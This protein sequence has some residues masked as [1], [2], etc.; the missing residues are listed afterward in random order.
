VIALATEQPSLVSD[1]CGL[2]R[3]IEVG[4]RG[5]GAVASPKL[6]RFA[7]RKARG[8][9]SRGAM[10]TVRLAQDTTFSFPLAD[11][12]WS[13]AF[14]QKA[15]YEIEIGDL[16]KSLR[17]EQYAFIDCG[18]NYG[19]W[20]V[21]VTSVAYGSHD[22]LAVELSPANTEILKINARGN[23]DRFKVVNAAVAARAGQ[24]VK[25]FGSNHF[26]HTITPDDD[27]KGGQLQP[28]EARTTTL[29][30]CAKSLQSRDGKYIVKLDVEGAE[31]EAM[32][33]AKTL[34]KQ[35][36]LVLYEDEKS[37]SSHRVSSFMIKELGLAVFAIAPATPPR[38]VSALR[39]IATM[40]A[41]GVNNF[42]ASRM[43]SFWT[44]HL[45][46]MTA[47]GKFGE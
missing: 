40:K 33:G 12:Y 45:N 30:D 19:Y 13:R 29:D 28:F 38:P 10:T 3:Y 23:G 46:A 11:S 35:E 24:L 27:T 41:A 31:C 39:D 26:G 4:L 18:A 6:F 34:M 43:D 7:S 44:Q 9:V 15:G 16:L 36:T 47:M 22:A 17:N 8:L 42:A 14:F 20:S 1:V 21:M 25:V 37:D 32:R 5:F 2:D